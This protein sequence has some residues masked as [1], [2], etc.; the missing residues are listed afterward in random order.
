MNVAGVWI[1]S[2]VFTPFIVKNPG[3]NSAV[4]DD[5]SDSL[6]LLCGKPN[7]ISKMG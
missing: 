2:R 3:G 1:D 4:V 5:I 7:L 6:V